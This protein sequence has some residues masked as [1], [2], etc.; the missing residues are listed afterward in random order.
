MEG[1]GRSDRPM[2]SRRRAS[3][4]RRLFR[5]CADCAPP[6]RARRTDARPARGG[7]TGA[8]DPAGRD[9]G[10]V[11]ARP[12]ARFRRRVPAV[13]EDAPALA[14]RVGRRA[15]RTRACRRST[16]VQVGDD[17]AVARRP[18]PRVGRPRPRRGDDRRRSSPREWTTPPAAR[19]RPGR[20]RPRSACARR[21][22]PELARAGGNARGRPTSRS[23]SGQASVS[24]TS[25][26]ASPVKR[27][28]ASRCWRRRSRARRRRRARAVAPPGGIRSGCTVVPAERDPAPALAAQQRGQERTQPRGRAGARRALGQQRLR[29]QPGG[30]DRGHR[31]RATG[32]RELERD[33]AAERVARDV[34]AV[35]AEPVVD[36]RAPRS[37]GAAR[38]I[39]GESPKPGMSTREDLALGG[40]P[41]EHRIPHVPVGAEGVQ[42]HE[43]RPAPDAVEGDHR[44]GED[45][46]AERRRAARDRGGLR[47]PRR[48]GCPRA[49]GER[50][51]DVVEVAGR[52][53]PPATAPAAARAAPRRRSR[54]R[55]AAPRAPPS[56]AQRD[57]GRVAR[58]GR[59]R[60]S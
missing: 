41:V 48:P 40:E 12:G 18:P 16:V 33:P 20:G 2:R 55:A 47:R 32:Q 36:R 45:G 6:D 42:Q 14:A 28:R 1:E 30:R 25:M 5:R 52:C 11:R 17:Y 19:R 35:E 4:A 46:G 38:A 29:P 10:H 27:P 23:C 50:G 8:R 37:A 26:S 58:P 44:G 39:T 57:L 43:R 56:A 9:H 60:I 34:R 59:A 54:S 22:E 31:A 21:R 7:G 15:H 13:E 49:A 24:G 53:W 3:L 51:R